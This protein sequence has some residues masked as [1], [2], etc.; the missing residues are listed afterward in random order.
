MHIHPKLRKARRN[1]MT[2]TP[3]DLNGQTPEREAPQEIR[4]TVVTALAFRNAVDELVRFAYAARSLGLA[5]WGFGIVFAGVAVVL[6]FW[7]ATDMGEPE[8]VSCIVFA[9]MLVLGGYCLYVLESRGYV[10]LV[11]EF[12]VKEP[13]AIADTPAD[14]SAGVAVATAH[15]DPAIAPN[16]GGGVAAI[17]SSGTAEPAAA[18]LG[19]AKSG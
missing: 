1:E 6:R 8:F 11:S 13:G 2:A 17:A 12:A 9:T 7:K 5:S 19:G 10:K 18:P 3:P 15:S 4:L 16:V 14:R